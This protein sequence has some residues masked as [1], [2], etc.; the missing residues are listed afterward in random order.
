MPNLM[1]GAETGAAAKDQDER[2]VV[3]HLSARNLTPN[4]APERVTQPRIR[5]NS[6]IVDLIGSS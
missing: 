1:N 3:G 2:L 4:E 5:L 6:A